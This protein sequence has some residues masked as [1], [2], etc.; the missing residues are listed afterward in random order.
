[1]AQERKTTQGDRTKEVAAI[2]VK[3][4]PFWPEQPTLWFAQLEARFAVAGVTQDATKLEY[5]VGNLEGRYALEVTDIITTP[6]ATGKYEKIKSELIARLSKS[7]E[8]KVR[9]VL[10]QEELGD[11]TPGQFL[12]HLRNLGGVAIPEGLIRT[13]W[14]SRLPD[15]IRT[16][17]ATQTKATLEET[18]ALADR[19]FE[20]TPQRGVKQLRRY[21][22][23]I[24]FYRRFIPN[25]ATF[26]APLEEQIGGT[27]NSSQQVVWS[28]RTEEAFRKSK[29]ALVNATILAHPSLQARIALMVDASDFAVGAALQQE[30]KG[31]WQPLAFFSK[32][33]NTAQRRYS[34]YDRELL[35]AYLSVK[36]FKFML[37][38]R[39]FTIFTDHK[40]L[41]Y[42][43]TQKLEK[44]SPMQSR[45]L[46]YLS[47][48]TTDIQHISGK[49]NIIADALSRVEEISTSIDFKQLQEDQ[50]TDIELQEYRKGNSNL[51]LRKLYLPES[52]TEH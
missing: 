2:G 47:Q 19:I 26:L 4:P 48:F 52:Q 43:F 8:T 37:E 38:G 40:P 10:E 25:V 44:C 18:S 3:V 1:M 31:Q 42:A 45:F 51:L 35:A 50:R 27:G 28:P 6:P 13:I 41:T 16:I 46:S 12:R 34:T 15:A 36:H 33:L 7:E 5:V 17:M 14:I 30:V 22:G 24:N 39:N 21:L 29:E 11:R 32:K 9:Q 20:L 49:D 23:M